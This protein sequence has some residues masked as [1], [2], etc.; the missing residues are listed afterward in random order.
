M[1]L[2]V[3]IETSIVSVL[4]ARPARDLILA[5]QQTRTI[6]WWERQ[7]ASFNL[8]SS[9]LVQLEASGGDTTAADERLKVLSSLP[10]LNVS[11]EALRLARQL[12]IAAALPPRA[13]RDAEHVGICATN[14]I[15][16]LLTWNCRHL[17]NAMQRGRI[18]Q[19]CE[20][21]GLQAPVICTP[22]ELFGDSHD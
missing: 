19:V 4:T 21:F 1:A 18:R 2:T 6:E 9:E 16:F 13:L 12:V 17:A 3:Y 14:A 8:Y 5:A 11:E 7:R 22:D 15:D 20:S 10:F